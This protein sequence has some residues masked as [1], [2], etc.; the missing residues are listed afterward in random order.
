MEAILGVRLY[1]AHALGLVAFVDMLLS[2]G[3]DASS[4]AASAC[5]WAL[6]NLRPGGD[7]Q[8]M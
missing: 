6:G 3:A 4:R 5:A 8:H 7:V 2:A 1:S